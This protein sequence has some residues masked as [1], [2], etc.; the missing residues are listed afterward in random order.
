MSRFL[1]SMAFAVKRD[2]LIAL[3]IF[4]LIMVVVNMVFS[5]ICVH[6]HITD[7][8]YY[9]MMMNIVLV[10]AFHF[11]YLV[12]KY[13]KFNFFKANSEKV[14]FLINQQQ[15][16]IKRYDEELQKVEQLRD[17]LN[18]SPLMVVKWDSHGKHIITQVLGQQKIL[19]YTDEEFINLKFYDIIHPDDRNMV[20]DSFNSNVLAELKY[21]TCEYRLK[22]KEGDYK[23]VVDETRTLKDKADKIIGFD[24][25]ILDISDR[26]RIEWQL[27][28]IHQRLTL[29]SRTACLGVWDWNIETGTFLFDDG[30]CSMYGITKAEFLCRYDD[31]TKWIHPDDIGK[32]REIFANMI[33]KH[34]DEFDSEF[35]IVRKDGAVRHIKAHASIYLDKEVPVRMVGLC[36]DITDMHK[37]QIDNNNKL[38]LINKLMEAMPSP[39]FYKDVNGTYTGCNSAFE[40][41]LGK[42]R[43]EIIGKTVVDVLGA[44]YASEH[45]KQ[46]Q[47]LFAT[48]GVRVYE[49]EINTHSGLKKVLISKSTFNDEDGSIE[50]II[51]L[52]T[53][54]TEHELSRTQSITLPD[55]FPLPDS[56][57][58][59]K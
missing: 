4:L 26:K 59:L 44:K 33:D 28:D 14:A 45:L 13:E 36:W 24:A 41:F 46:D 58:Q 40:N 56:L 42:K 8:D 2:N 15:S 19:G 53:D 37:M 38:N 52:I 1:N 54:L 10:V 7:N 55:S 20:S 50:G 30:M 11:Y 25:I 17:F 6:M 16:L 39:I 12:T 5:L 21:W 9:Q 23:W 47:A 48:G 32:V 29:A 57:P 35:R 31:W 3:V 34:L 22:T 43:S 18:R 49:M 27:T 51:G